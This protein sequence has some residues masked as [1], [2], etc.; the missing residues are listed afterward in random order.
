MKKLFL[1]LVVMSIT[2]TISTSFAQPGDRMQMTPEQMAAQKEK[3]KA[4]LMEDLK[5]TDAQ[6]D[7]VIGVQT[8]MRKQMM[9]LRGLEPEERM[10]KMKEIN[11]MRMKKYTEALKDEA[12]AKKV[13]DY[14]AEQNK[15]RMERRK[16][17]SGQ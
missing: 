6:A 17:Q 9:E 4:K 14:E 16:E 8:E 11:E 5:L 2:A 13:M 1:L 10:A 3:Q 15:L 12:L 7:A